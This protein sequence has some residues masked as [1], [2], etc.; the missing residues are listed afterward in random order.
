MNPNKVIKREPVGA[1]AAP[2]LRLYTVK[3]T[4]CPQRLIEAWNPEEAKARYREWYRL[5]PSRTVEAVE[6]VDHADAG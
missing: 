3:H 1:Q 6:V 5:H 2:A 4:D